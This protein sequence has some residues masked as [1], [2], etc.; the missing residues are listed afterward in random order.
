MRS[1]ISAETHDR[2]WAEMC[3]HDSVYAR[4]IARLSWFLNPLFAP[5]DRYARR[6]A[7]FGPHQDLIAYAEKRNL[8]WSGYFTRQW[9]C[10]KVEK[11]SQWIEQK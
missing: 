10:P 3:K 9:I 4:I 6:K 11:D 2:A 8:V 1:H 7:D 5:F